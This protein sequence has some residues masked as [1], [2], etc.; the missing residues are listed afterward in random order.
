METDPVLG[1]EFFGREEIL[2]ALEKRLQSFLKGYRQ[3]VGLIGPKSVGKSSLVQHFLLGLQDPSLIAVYAEVLPE[4]FD[5]FA[6]KFMG[7]LLAA[8]LRSRQ[9]DT[10][11]EFSGLISK[12]KRFIPK[13]LKKMRE[14]KKK[15]AAEE[16]DPAFRELLSLTQIL[17]EE[18]GKKVLLVLDN[19]DRLDELLLHDPFHD[20]GNA[21]M[22]QTETFYVV[23]SGRIRRAREIFNKDLSL[24]FG[25]FEILEIKPFD[26]AMSQVFLEKKLSGAAL[27]EFLKKFLVELTDGHPYF[28]SVLA[29]RSHALLGP[30]EAPVTEEI[31]IA[32]LEKELYDRKGELHRYF[33]M[34]LQNLGQGRTLY[35]AL[36]VLMAVSMGH[37]KNHQIAK[38]LNR[39]VDDIKKTLTRLL[40]EEFLEKKGS[41]FKINSPFFGFWL[42]YVYYRREFAF[43][44]PAEYT[45]KAFRREVR[46]L[47]QQRM[48]GGEKEIT[49]RVEELFREF[50]NDVVELEDKK[51]RCP[52]FTEV[53]FKPSNGRVFPVEAKAL[54]TRWICQVAYKRVTEDDVR[55][56]IQDIDKLRKKVQRKIMIALEG[57]ELNA[58]LLAKESKILLWRLKEFNE[59]LELYGRPKVIA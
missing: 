48:E 24:L 32:A 20:F 57:I 41:F 2:Q 42:R 37:R 31:L 14:I 58:K 43:V 28:L 45:A 19:F 4:P 36:K 55:L 13:T 49:K 5:Y 18:S 54:D 7:S 50:Q 53:H 25:N 15:L 39:R 46:A 3:N 9:E 33:A 51:I 16:W 26:F 10:E 11:G 38:F 35:A 52:H 12:S 44:G 8:F 34:F 23:T 6:Q 21:I 27:S 56:F 30:G 17:G 59:L 40:E 47:I 29:G 22:A 1:A